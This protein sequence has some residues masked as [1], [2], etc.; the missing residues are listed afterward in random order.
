MKNQ[1]ERIA[2]SRKRRAEIEAEA[3]V[4]VARH[5]QDA[6]VKTYEVER[7]QEEAR[8]NQRVKME[9]LAGRETAE[10]A[11]MAEAAERASEEARI[12]RQKAIEI[13]EED[14]QRA[15]EI[16]RQE[17]Q[18]AVA[19]K[20]EE[21]SQARARAD[22]ARADAATAEESVETAR[23]VASGE[24]KKR[25]TLISAEEE[26]ERLATSIRI[27]ATAERAAASDRAEAMRE[28]ARAEADEI[29]I[30]AEANKMEKLADAEGTRALIDAE[31]SLSAQIIEFRL[32]KARLE[33][34]PGIVA[35]M[36]KP[37]EKIG[38]ITIHK[39]DGLNGGGS[40]TTNGGTGGGGLVNQA[41]DE[42]RSMAFQLPAI[43]A[44]GKQVGINMETGLA[45]LLNGEFSVDGMSDQITGATPETGYGGAVFSTAA[46]RTIS[47][48]KTKA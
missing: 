41:F 22:L 3:E 28:I 15:I 30:K 44:I 1:A 13:A 27:S 19:I 38:G 39:V 11:R 17:R 47:S 25:L 6:V 5:K 26:A 48:V 10:K 16:A 37:A 24:R 12:E 14:R 36:V 40:G 20:S 43:T 21:E 46:D 18:I 7:E 23:Q 32:S 45:G 34:L 8:V 33:A 31:N 29:T 4:A 9:E 35:E 42:L 2:E